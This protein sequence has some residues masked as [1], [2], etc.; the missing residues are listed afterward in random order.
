MA[1]LRGSESDL[2][3]LRAA[4]YTATD[5][6]QAAQSAMYEANSEVS[7]LEAE[8]RYVVE[9]RNRVQAQLAALTSQREQWQARCAQ[10]EE[11]LAL[12]EEELVIAEE[13][14]ATAQDQAAEQNDA[15][16]ALESRWRDAQNLLNQPGRRFVDPSSILN[17]K[18][19]ATGGAIE[20]YTIEWERFG[21]RYSGGIRVTF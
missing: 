3:T 9:S 8:I 13:R 1:R 21:R 2:E 20:N 5:A 14:A 18:G 19:I 12:A 7:R 6:V 11:A 10:S 16:P 15:L 17:A 4:H